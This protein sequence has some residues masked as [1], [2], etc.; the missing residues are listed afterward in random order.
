MEYHEY[1]MMIY[2]IVST[3][4]C[5]TYLHLGI[6]LL[7]FGKNSP[8]QKAFVALCAML[9]LWSFGSIG[10]QLF[11]GSRWDSL[12]ERI[13][14]TGSEL[15]ILAGIIF[16]L[17]LTE[18]AKSPAYRFILLVI[19]VRITIYQS[20]NWGWNL[21]SRDFPLGL[22][23]MS[24][25]LFSVAEAFLIP[26]IALIWGLNSPL[27]R[28]RVQAKIIVISTILG[29]II[30]V[31]VD[32]LSGAKGYNPISCVIPVLWMVPICFAIMRYGLMRFAPA[33]VNRE[34]IKHM[35]R[36]VFM[37]D[38]SWNITD[39]ND[40]ARF[41]IE[42]TGEQKQPIPM[43]DVFLDAKAIIRRAKASMEAAS[44][45]FTQTGFLRTFGGH[46]VPVV[47]SFSIISDKWGDRIGILGICNPH[48]D[49]RGFVN[50]YNLSERQTDIVRHIISGRSQVQTS[51]ELFISLA[52]VKTH[53]T[54]LYNRLGISSRSELYAL[55]RGE[56]PSWI[57][58]SR[59]D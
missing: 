33:H 4:A 35:D 17:I 59:E 15:F 1:A 16:I 23:F 53:T 30:G 18:K 10:Q 37:I 34:L 5:V 31:S 57:T 2:A 43:E 20:A 13:Y 52:T 7:V 6:L 45:Y 48:L 47:T 28:E 8:T 21:L 44:T 38:S 56:S 36:A 50:R 40:A 11:Q 24:H 51:E 12:F 32:S 49:L 19:I 29:T 25:Q 54:A 46:S 58:S 9:T 27:H 39:L 22:W 41:L 3:A 42:S 26:T 55:L 14:F